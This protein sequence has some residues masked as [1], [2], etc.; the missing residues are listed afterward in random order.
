MTS[1]A[2]LLAL[3]SAHAQDTHEQKLAAVATEAEMVLTAPTAEPGFK[4]GS[5]VQRYQAPPKVNPI[6]EQV[7]TF[8]AAPSACSKL[9]TVSEVAAT[10]SEKVLWI[11]DSGVGMALGL[12]QFG[13]NKGLKYKAIAGLEYTL[14]GKAVVEG[15]LETMTDCCMHQ[16]DQCDGEFVT[17]VWRGTGTLHKLEAELYALKGSTKAIEKH[18]SITY[19]KAVG[20]SEASSWG[21]SQYFAFKSEPFTFPAC[22]AYMGASPQEEGKVLFVGVSEAS[23][24]ETAAYE[25]A[26]TDLQSQVEKHMA[27]AR[28]AAAET[29]DAAEDKAE[30]GEGETEDLSAAAQAVMPDAETLIHCIDAPVEVL[31]EPK[32]VARVR[33][34]IE[35]DK[36]APATVEEEAE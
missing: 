16:P 5:L 4:A 31:D 1:L 34:Y 14:D 21:E 11:M 20:W 12:P 8:K 35:A 28:K 7:G 10:D 32:P 24:S 15:G 29:D 9:L 2:L 23:A 33:M 22:A 3:S 36:L 17:E 18:G 27:E 13:L 25:A 26:L 30:A 6:A 19:E